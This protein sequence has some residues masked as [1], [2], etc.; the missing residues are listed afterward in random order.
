MINGTLQ[1]PA[2][3]DPYIN[4]QLGEGAILLADKGY[5]SN[6]IRAKAFE[7]KA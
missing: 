1:P 2:V 3:S 6:A 7:R 5:D 4:T